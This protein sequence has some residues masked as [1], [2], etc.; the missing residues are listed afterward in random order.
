[1]W[2]QVLVCLHVHTHIH[3]P[4]CGRSEVRLGVFLGLQ[5]RAAP[6]LLCGFQGSGTQACVAITLPTEPYPQPLKYF[7]L[8]RSVI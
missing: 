1:M 5:T 3:V 2:V 4:T 6:S 8:R 7:F